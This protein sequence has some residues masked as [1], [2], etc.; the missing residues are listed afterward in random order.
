MRIEKQ[1]PHQNPGLQ[2]TANKTAEGQTF[3]Q[4]LAQAAGHSDD[5]LSAASPGGEGSRKGRDR[6]SVV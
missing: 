5:F 1:F 6:K 2:K 4:A 3:Q